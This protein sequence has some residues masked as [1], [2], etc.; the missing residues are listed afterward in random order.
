MM[1]VNLRKLAC[2]ILIIAV[3]VGGLLLVENVHAVIYVS[4]TIGN[5]LGQQEVLT[6]FRP[7]QL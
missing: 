2:I 4:G 1:G 7:I 5:Q 3:M 6:H